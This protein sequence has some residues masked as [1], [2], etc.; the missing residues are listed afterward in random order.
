MKILLRTLFFCI[1][2]S[3]LLF[4]ASEVEASSG[5]SLSFRHE[6][7][8]DGE[9]VTTIFLDTGE[10]EINAITADF[11]YPS[12]LLEVV[13]IKTS[14]SI[15]ENFIELDHSLDGIV[16]ISGYSTEGISDEG[17]VATVVFKTLS[18]GVAQLKFTEETAVLS[19]SN[20]SNILD[21]KEET[22]YTITDTLSALP[23][24]GSETRV[25]AGIL[26][27]ILLVMIV[28]FALLGFTIWGGIY[29]SLGKWKVEGKYEVGMGKS[30]KRKSKS[31]KRGSKKKKP[32]KKKK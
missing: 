19:S 17:T 12:N 9:I 1:T 2:L 13:E 7:F 8:S 10:K 30:K 25:A 28:I 29:F 14:K 32:T 11:T 31:K 18:P 15:F 27:I 4:S 21:K 16:F 26:A 22:Q 5:A 24:T 6:D 3:I 23:A 20:S